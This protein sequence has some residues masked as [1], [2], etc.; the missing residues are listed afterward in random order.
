[1]FSAV[2][3]ETQDWLQQHQKQAHRSAVQ[4]MMGIKK[5]STGSSTRESAL[6][7]ELMLLASS[8]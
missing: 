7:Q 1:M 4:P 2:F 5:R 8:E 6:R 3:I